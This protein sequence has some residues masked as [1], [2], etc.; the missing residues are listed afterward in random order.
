M[1]WCLIVLGIV[2]RFS[3]LDRKAYW[4]D[5][6]LTLQHISG[7]ASNEIHDRLIVS[8]QPFQFKDLKQFQEYTP[9]RGPQQVLNSITYSQPAHTPLF[10][11][12]AHFWASA[13]G[14]EKGSMR[15]LPAF[16]SLLQL[17][18]IYWFMIELFAAPVAA[19]LAVAL[20]ALSPLQL[21]YAQELR[22]YSLFAAIVPLTSAALLRAINNSTWRTWLLYLF[23]LV[24]GFYFSLLTVFVFASQFVYLLCHFGLKWN[25]TTSSFLL[26][27][28]I[29][30]LCFLPW[31][32]IVAVNARAAYLSLRWLTVPVSMPVWINSWC[33]NVSKIFVDLGPNYFQFSNGLSA[34]VLLL[35]A[36]AFYKLLRS[37]TKERSFLIVTLLL[38]PAIVLATG[39]LILGGQRSLQIKYVMS[40]PIAILLSV[41]YLLYTGQ[42]GPIAM[43]WFWRGL[44]CFIFAGEIASCLIIVQ[45]NVWSTKTVKN[46]NVAE[47]ARI[48]NNDPQAVMVS[49]DSSVLL[50]QQ[51]NFP[52]LMVLTHLVRPEIYL[53]FSD[54]PRLPTLLPG[55]KHYYLLNPSLETL[56]LCG[57]HGFNISPVDNLSYLYL[58]TLKREDK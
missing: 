35:E 39:D 20:V 53:E 56:N 18:C 21:L 33:D 49:E 8:G 34:V 31:F 46:Q 23:S 10:Y 50:D 55:I 3:Q 44:T 14:C 5:E 32:A 37:G 38:V 19:E 4:C 29:A 36:Y 9:G 57:A 25:K 13:F 11:E 51:T 15:C 26:T 17:P 47:L 40:V 30:L 2:L 42:N 27:S 43:R 24:L 54:M 41:S 16:L 6:T 28:A 1:L 52:Q 22:E 12:I 45:A 7:Y 58:A 48:I